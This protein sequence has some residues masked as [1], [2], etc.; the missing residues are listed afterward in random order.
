LQATST[1]T[2]HKPLFFFFTLVSLIIVDV[3]PGQDF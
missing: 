3:G 1:N 2:H